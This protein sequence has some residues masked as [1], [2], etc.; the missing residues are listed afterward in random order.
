ML[1]IKSNGVELAYERVGKGTPLVLIHGHPLDHTIWEPIL[2][3]LENDFELIVPDLRGF[4]HSE[5]VQSDYRLIDMAAD[6][7]ALLDN[8]GI[9]QAA[10]GGHSM[11]GYVALA[12]WRVFP[13]RIRGLGLVASHIYADSPE[14]KSSRYETA[15]EINKHGVTIL[16][17]SFPA[18]LT[19]NL[20]LRKRLQ[21]IILRQSVYGVAES[22]RAMAERDDSSDLVVNLNFPMVVIHGTHDVLV[23]IERARDAKLLAEGINLVE[24]VGAGH[25]PM[26]EEPLKTAEALRMLK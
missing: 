18:K 3:L 13:D 14:R 5:T 21:E 2:P 4:G 17:D 19:A 8:L 1:K 6:I 22:L 11:G 23:P 25:M 16:A 15:S 7:R 20:L 26:M 9:K 24:I 10:F 12:F